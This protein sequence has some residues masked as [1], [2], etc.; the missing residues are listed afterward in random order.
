M[1][2]KLLLVVGLLFLGS[3]V[4]IHLGCPFLLIP[5]IIPFWLTNRNPK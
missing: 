1:D 4:A 5:L 2:R 3:L